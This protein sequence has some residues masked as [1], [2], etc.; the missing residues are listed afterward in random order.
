[1]KILSLIFCLFV[2]FGNADVMRIDAQEVVVDT[3]TKLMWQDNRDVEKVNQDLQG[4]RVYCENLIFAGLSDWRL[5]IMDDFF[6]IRDEKRANIAINVAFKHVIP[7]NYWSSSNVYDTGYAWSINFENGD[8]S[9]Q[10]KNS[11]FYVRCVR[12]N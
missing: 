6:S 3:N 11:N 2:V 9:L 5:P 12:D 4:A 10:L 7:K 1:M 8:D